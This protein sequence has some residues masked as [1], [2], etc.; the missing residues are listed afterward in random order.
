ML[1]RKTSRW[2]GVPKSEKA[3]YSSTTATPGQDASFALL[4]AAG[5]VSGV[6]MPVAGTSCDT[7]T[8]PT[9]FT[10]QN[11][12]DRLAENGDLWQ[13]HLQEQ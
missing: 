5:V 9:H 4:G 8:Y 7:Y 6:S 12:C 13:Q 2:S 11:A 1:T 3:R 10:I